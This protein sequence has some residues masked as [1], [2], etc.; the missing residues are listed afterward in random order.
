M[1]ALMHVDAV[2]ARLLQRLYLLGREH[3]VLVFGELVSLDDLVL[4]DRISGFVGGVLD[5][6]RQ[7]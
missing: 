2:R 5:G 7:D 4:P 6:G 1:C 3:H